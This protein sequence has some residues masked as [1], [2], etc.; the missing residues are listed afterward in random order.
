[1]AFVKAN[2]IAYGL[3]DIDTLSIPYSHYIVNDWP[4]VA[5]HTAGSGVEVEK[6]ISDGVAVPVVASYGMTSGFTDDPSS[7]NPQGITAPMLLYNPASPPTAAQMQGKILVFKAVPYTAPVANMNGVYSYST[8]FLDS[9]VLTDNEYRTPGDNWYPNFQAVPASVNSGYWYR[10]NWSQIG[11]FATIGIKNGAAGMVVVYDLAPDGALGLIQRSV[12]TS[13]GT[14]KTPYVNVPTLCLDRVNGAKVLTDAQAGKTATLILKAKFQTDTGQ[15]L[16]GFLPGKDYGTPQDKWIMLAT[17]TDAMSLVEEDGALGILGILNYFNQIPQ[18]D[19]PRTL[20]I[21]FDCRHF[22][23]GAEGSWPQYDYYDA[24]TFPARYA[25]MMSHTVAGMGMEHMGARATIETGVDGNTYG[26]A[27]GG[28][29]SGGLITSFID[30]YNNNPKLLAIVK[31][32]ATDNSWPRVEAHMGTVEPGINGGYQTTPKSPVNKGRTYGFPGIGLAGDWPGCCTQTFAQLQTFDPNYFVTQ[33]A[34]LSEIAGNLMLV[35]PYVIDMSWGSI[36]SGLVCTDKTICTS[37]PASGLL[38]DSA[39]KVP[40]SAPGQRQTL[41]SLYNQAFA[42]V[43][44]GDYVGTATL[45][46]TLATNANN[47]VSNPTAMVNLINALIA[48]L[49]KTNK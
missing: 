36:K 6:L 44:V 45:L 5:T 41:I 1:M 40:A 2:A 17:H 11:G 49:P 13:D 26:F 22:M 18:S 48:K 31:A 10:W 16:I 20:L 30:I 43:Q 27:P 32:A 9:Y 8:S 37:T 24:T 35:D 15:A 47:Y 12:Y 19:R 4:D 42:T 3:V 38:P 21:F 25:N 7:T 39:F 28:P 23:P 33:V 14:P 29:N 34:G 46:N